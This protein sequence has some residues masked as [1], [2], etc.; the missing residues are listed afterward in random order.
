MKYDYVFSVLSKFGLWFYKYFLL[1]NFNYM[2]VHLQLY[3]YPVTLMLFCKTSLVIWSETNHEAK[4]TWRY[5][6]SFKLLFSFSLIQLFELVTD[7]IGFVSCFWSD[8]RAAFSWTQKVAQASKDAERRGLAFLPS[9]NTEMAGVL[10]SPAML[11]YVCLKY[12]SNY[13]LILNGK[14]V[15]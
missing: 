15:I 14:N 12:L 10:L 2:E 9:I 7:C 6:F 13:G 4:M 1:L 11:A 5:I 8:L 3:L